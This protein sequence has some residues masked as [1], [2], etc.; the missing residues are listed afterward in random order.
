MNGAETGTTP[1]E[2]N[3]F[4]GGRRLISNGPFMESWYHSQ[5]ESNPRPGPSGPGRPPWRHRF[6]NIAGA[7]ASP[8][9]RGIE[10]GSSG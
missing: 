2:S 10:S 6:N 9:P 4:S 8:G 5:G 3:N 7:V 1:V